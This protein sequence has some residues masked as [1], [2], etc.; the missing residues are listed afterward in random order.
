MRSHHGPLSA[1]FEKI[2]DCHYLVHF[3]G[4]AAKIM[5]FYYTVAMT[6]TG[7]DGVTV[8]LSAS[9]QLPIFGTFECC[10]SANGCRFEARYSA[11]NDQG[12]FRLERR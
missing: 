5:P 2:D 8:F 12:V 1:R 6:V 4:R 7:C 3:H 11:S 10:A 9:R